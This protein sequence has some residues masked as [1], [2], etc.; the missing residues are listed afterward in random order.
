[1]LTQK[2]KK[3]IERE[4]QRIR[5]QTLGGG[6]E[7]RRVLIPPCV[8]IMPC[9]YVKREELWDRIKQFVFGR[10]ATLIAR[11]YS[12]ACQVFFFLSK[13]ERKRERNL[14]R[15]FTRPYVER[16]ELKKK[17]LGTVREK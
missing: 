9:L 8:V 6:G 3:I 16:E 17:K 15:I 5:G 10:E 2:T 7:R 11:S 1:L 13:K 14:C 12:G 4:K